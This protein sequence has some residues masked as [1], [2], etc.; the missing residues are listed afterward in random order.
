MGLLKLFNVANYR[1][2]VAGTSGGGFTLPPFMQGDTMSVE[3]TLLEDT[4]A[5]GLL[6]NPSYAK[7]APSGYTLKMGLFRTSDS[8]QLAYQNSWTLDAGNNKYT[9]SLALNTAAIAT[10]M[11]GQT[12]VACT[13]EIEVTDS[14]GYITTPFQSSTTLIKEYITTGVVGV[15]PT[16]IGAAQSWVQNLFVPVVQSVAVV[17]TWKSPNGQPFLVYVGD[18]GLLHADPVT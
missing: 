17:Q 3:Y 2:L 4:S 5:A 16:E 8:T 18:D 6:A 14:S 13:F 7:V 12:S 1:S 9:G 10:A 11:S 15:A